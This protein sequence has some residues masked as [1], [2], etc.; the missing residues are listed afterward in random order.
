MVMFDHLDLTVRFS[1]PQLS[2][3]K[4]ICYDKRQS[5]YVLYNED[6]D[7]LIIFKS[8][9]INGTQEFMDYK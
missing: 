8:K 6:E 5:Q 9:M 4:N 2:N 3:R 1:W 7:G